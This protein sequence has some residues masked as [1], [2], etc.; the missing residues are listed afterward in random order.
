MPA[1]PRNAFETTTWQQVA[2]W[3]EEEIERMR[4]R[5]EDPKL[6][7]ESTATLRGEIRAYR[8]LLRQADPESPPP[9]TET[10]TYDL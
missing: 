4:D 3:L 2:A 5:N 7:S 8:R 1:I 6:S 9:T 10:P